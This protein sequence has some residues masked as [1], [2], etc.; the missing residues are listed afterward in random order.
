MKNIDTK[1]SVY[2][3][4]YTLYTQTFKKSGMID[5]IFNQFIQLIIIRFYYSAF[6]CFYETRFIVEHI[7]IILCTCHNYYKKLS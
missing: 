3:L 2:I 7:I 1:F 6:L 4:F 5:I